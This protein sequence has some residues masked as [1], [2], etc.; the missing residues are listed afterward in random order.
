MFI[1]IYVE[2]N[3]QV[4]FRVPNN[5]FIYN[6]ERMLLHCT[7][8]PIS[9][10]CP[11]L[12]KSR[13]FFVTFCQSKSKEF[14]FWHWSTYI[15]DTLEILLIIFFSILFYCSPLKDA[16]KSPKHRAYLRFSRILWTCYTTSSSASAR[17]SSRQPTPY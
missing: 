9:L 13:L 15:H 17:P 3:F 7:F 11:T 2:F 6:P 4:G 14:C 10:F 16:E 8:A 5:P 12:E 1:S